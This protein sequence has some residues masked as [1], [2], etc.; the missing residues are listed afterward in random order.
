MGG[1]K[2]N[3]RRFKLKKKVKK[4]KKVND[5]RTFHIMKYRALPE[6]IKGIRVQ[7]KDKDIK[8][9][10]ETIYSRSGTTITVINALKEKTRI[11]LDRVI[12]YWHPM[13][14]ASPENKIRLRKNLV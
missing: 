7:F 10:V 11:E 6:L 8:T 1:A 2:K 4:G 3:R 13:V 9:R 14:K 12:G 5:S